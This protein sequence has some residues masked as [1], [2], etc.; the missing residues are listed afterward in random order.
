MLSGTSLSADPGLVAKAI[1]E[2]TDDVIFAKGLDCRYQFANPAMLA[3]LACTREQVVGHTD[4]EFLRDPA[5]VGCLAG[6]AAELARLLE[7]GDGERSP[8][9][10]STVN[11]GPIAA[12]AR[13]AR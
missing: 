4:A 7:L 1:A 8:S 9:A 13:R 10:W 3:A 5:T 2:A 12:S 6:I 11:A